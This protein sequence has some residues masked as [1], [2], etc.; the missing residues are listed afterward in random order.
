MI[1]WQVTK[2]SANYAALVFCL[3]Y[4]LCFPVPYYFLPNVGSWSLPLLN[5]LIESIG[6]NVLGF[7]DG[8]VTEL[9]SDSTGHYIFTVG[10]LI[11]SVLSGIAT[12]IVGK[13]EINPKLMYWFHTAL[14][15]YLALTLFKY[16]ADKIFKHQFYL[17][18]PNTLFTPVGQMT[19]DMLFWSSM[20]SSYSY[21]VFAGI[22]E[23]IP[24]LLLLFRKTRVLGTIIATAVMI[25]VVMLN[26]GFDIT[27]KLYSLFLLFI[28]FILLSPHLKSI[29]NLFIK[30]KQGALVIE[31][32][33]PIT[34]SQLRFY[35][36]SKTI[37]IGLIAYESC[38]FYF[39]TNNLNDDLS[40]RPE[41]HGAYD[42]YL[43]TDNGHIIPADMGHP[44]RFRRVFFHRQNYFIIQR[45]DDL[46]I[47]YKVQVDTTTK[48]LV[49]SESSWPA[50]HHH[51]S[52]LT[53]QVNE[54][55]LVIYGY[56]FDSYITLFAEKI[57]LEE[58]PLLKEDFHW[59]LDEF[60]NK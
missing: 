9:W 33:Q 50:H 37:A 34:K 59:T 25:N 24:A 46:F 53:Y 47:D 36:I 26:F 17:P 35:T 2:R 27:V 21:T 48:K 41:L 55:K 7:N 40:P 15:Y 38:G 42:I 49:L 58:L 14:S 45:M 43:L 18:E 13:K 51:T 39:A 3:I 54:N 29:W 60:K 19:P 1:F 31:G 52:E 20:G 12:A 30:S 56:F 4:L 6:R 10:L 28:C 23:V 11:V 16:G 57:N 32:Y 44:G 8:F 22:I 5:P